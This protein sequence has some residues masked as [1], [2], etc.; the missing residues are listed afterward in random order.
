MCLALPLAT[1]VMVSLVIGDHGSQIRFDQL[2]YSGD[3]FRRGVRITNAC[4]VS[5]MI[6]GSVDGSLSQVEW[7]IIRPGETYPG[8][9]EFRERAEDNRFAVSNVVPWVPPDQRSSTT[10]IVP[11]PKRVVKWVT[12]HSWSVTVK[13]KDC[14][15]G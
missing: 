1:A 10:T 3:R 15:S 11:I 14:P 7:G 2:G 13:G 6:Q 12:P 9:V 4:E 5:I 8:A